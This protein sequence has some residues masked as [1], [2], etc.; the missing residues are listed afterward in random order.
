MDKLQSDHGKKMLMADRLF[1]SN[2]KSIEKNSERRMKKK[3]CFGGHY[4]QATARPQITVSHTSFGDFNYLSANQSNTLKPCNMRLA[5]SL[6][7]AK[8]KSQE[9]FITKDTM[10]QPLNVIQ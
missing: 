1:S 8:T 9:R 2:L 7:K 10:K 5:T 4:K 6:I 3:S